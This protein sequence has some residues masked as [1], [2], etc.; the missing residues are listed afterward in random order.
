M[1][2]G[3]MVML[4]APCMLLDRSGL[5][6][7]VQKVLHILCFVQPCS[8]LQACVHGWLLEATPAEALTSHNPTTPVRIAELRLLESERRAMKLRVAA[9]IEAE[10]ARAMAAARQRGAEQRQRGQ[11]RRRGGRQLLFFGVSQTCPLHC[12]PMS[13]RFFLGAF[14]MQASTC[15]ADYVFPPCTQSAFLL[16][17]WQTHISHHATQDLQDTSSGRVHGRAPSSQGAAAAAGPGTGHAGSRNAS[18]SE[19]RRHRQ[20]Q[21]HGLLGGP[22]KAGGLCAGTQGS[23]EHRSSG[24]GSSGSGS[25]SDGDSEPDTEREGDGEQAGAPGTLPAGRDPLQQQ[26]QQQRGRSRS[27]Q[28]AAVG[29][30]AGAPHGPAATAAADAAALEA[31]EQ[32]LQRYSVLLAKARAFLQQQRRFVRERQEAILAAQAQWRADHEAYEQRR[33]AS[34]SGGGNGAGAGPGLP[35]EG[36]GDSAAAAQ[37]RRVKGVLQQQVHELND[38][39]RRLKSLKKQVRLGHALKGPR[40]EV[41]CLLW[42]DK[43]VQRAVC[44]SVLQLQGLR[45]CCAASCFHKCFAGPTTSCVASLHLLPSILRTSSTTPHPLFPT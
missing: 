1:R 39:T 30:A 8:C 33:G 34:G 36:E 4:P 37:L 31:L 29:G 22:S 10:E 26:Q 41:R 17:L 19:G 43:Q 24:D 16:A 32:D 3:A 27:L 20:Q 11:V 6:T 45:R 25:S 9:Q 40:Q 5:D 12:K 13:C 44:Q 2:V 21:Q 7:S 28:N 42:R 18:P 23:G 38:E 35:W 15:T 14:S